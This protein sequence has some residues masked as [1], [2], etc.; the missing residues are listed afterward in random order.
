[1]ELDLPGII[2]RGSIMYVYALTLVRISGKQSI[3]QLA[4]MDFVVT[5]VI[6]D[7]FDDVFWAEVPLVQG[8][9]GFGTVVLAHMLVTLVASRSRRIHELVNSA[10]RILIRDGKLLPENLRRE[11]I[12]QET[13]QFELRI[14]SEE[15]LREVEQATLE[16]EGQISV[17]KTPSSR[18]IQKKDA[19]R[20][21]R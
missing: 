6:G 8:L 19:R 9:V 2:L 11:W 16:P 1:M 3:G 17:I 21:L 12:R 10:P 13:V 7:L 5:L 18:P 4:A 14:S 15:R 20:L